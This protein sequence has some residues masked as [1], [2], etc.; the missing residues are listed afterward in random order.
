MELQKQMNC[1]TLLIPFPMT[2]VNDRFSQAGSTIDFSDVQV[3]QDPLIKGF[4]R[5]PVYRFH[6]D[7]YEGVGVDIVNET[8]FEYPYNF[9]TEKTYRPIACLRPFIIVGPHNTLGFLKSFGFQTFNTIIDESYDQVVEPEA[10]FHS[11]CASIK[12][13]VLQPV[14][15][16]KKD[17]LSI[18]PILK[19][20]YNILQELVDQ[21]LELFKLKIT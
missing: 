2:S 9:I 16:V 14:D 18:E 10:R 5:D 11:V 12:K 6:A 21:E 8:V 15:K 20:N 3:D 19:H 7:F 13:F 4:S 1:T 17:I